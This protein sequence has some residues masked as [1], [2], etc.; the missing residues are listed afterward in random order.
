MTILETFNNAVRLRTENKLDDCMEVTRRLW[1]KCQNPWL[2]LLRGNCWTDLGDFAQAMAW[3][4]TAWSMIAPNNIVKP[5]HARIF[6]DI[7]LPFAYSRLR[8]GLW[9]QFTWS[10]FEVGRLNRS[11]NPAPNTKPWGGQ[12]EKMIVLSEGGYGDAFLYTRF[13]RK[14]D[15]IQRGASRF[16]MGPQFKGLKGFRETWDG[17]ATISHDEIFDWSTFRYSTALM[18]LMAVMGIKSSAEIPQAETGIGERAWQPGG[19]RKF[20]LC[21]HAEENGVQKRIRSI[22]NE[23]DL[24]PLEGI[25]FYNLNPGRTLPQGMG[26]RTPRLLDTD[27]NTWKDTARLIAGLDCVVTVDTAV[28]H[29]AGLLNVPTL[30]I[31]PVASDWKMGLGSDKSWWW[32]SWTIVRNTSPYTFRPALERAAQI[33]EK[34]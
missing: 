24:A 29:L 13:F 23:D 31:V 19:K 34:L 28:A 21:W 12:P 27:L 9:D 3:H 8:L 16:V 25:P 18:S 4:Q 33:L 1:L 20:G 30:V 14:M 15:P 5:E 22:D 2:A 10:L 26:S 7:A 17:M 32:P 11:W 6:Q